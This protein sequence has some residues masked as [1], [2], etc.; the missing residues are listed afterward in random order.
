MEELLLIYLSY[1]RIS[2]S[3]LSQN[4]P[5]V[6]FCIRENVGAIHKPVFREDLHLFGEMG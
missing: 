1:P 5:I 3:S 2:S 6:L 4:H